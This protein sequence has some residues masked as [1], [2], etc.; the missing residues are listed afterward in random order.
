MN[1][2]LFIS[3][4]IAAVA[5]AILMAG[6]GE[7]PAPL[8][9]TPRPVKVEVVAQGASETAESFIGTLRAQRRADL[10]FESPGRIA[11]L[12]VDVGDHVRAG[13]VLARLDEAPA[14]WRLNKAVADRGAAAA[15]L[16]ERNTQLRQNESLARDHIISAAALESVQTQHQ[17]AT[18]QLQAADAA[19]A[20][21]Q[22]D[23]ALARITAPFDGEV[24]ARAVQP[25]TDIAAGQP[26]L[27]VEAGQALEVVAMLPDSVAARLAPGQ[28]AGAT[29]SAPQGTRSLPLRLARLSAHS[30]SGSLVQAVFAIESPVAGARSGGVVS[31]ELPR[32]T[33]ASL[34]LP[35][36]AVLPGAAPGRASV[37][38]LD[39]HGRL[40]RHAIQLGDGVLP[41][42]R[43]PVRSGL[44]PGEQV[45]VAGAAFLSEGQAAVRHEP[46]T[47][48]QAAAQ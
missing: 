39:T 35:A 28:S 2:N 20:Q 14:Q 4:A 24:V 43:L 36:Q 21:A 10:G 29:L 18:S 27:Q 48:L 15:S 6:C 8:A 22:R 16:A 42:G 26:V 34:S 30:E 7:T 31:V 9:E 41:N 13:Q 33:A 17:L 44:T 37:F 23:L 1:K 47:L 40:V 5:L 3:P 38:V 25:H 46:Q 32:T 12:L 11:A 45:V 19:L